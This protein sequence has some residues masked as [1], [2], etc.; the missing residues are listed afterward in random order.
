METLAATDPNNFEYFLFE[1]LYDPVIA[2]E[3]KIEIPFINIFLIKTYQ[4]YC[5]STIGI[6]FLVIT[7]VKDSHRVENQ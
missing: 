6:V 2:K 1:F 7:V 5:L 4:N 3:S